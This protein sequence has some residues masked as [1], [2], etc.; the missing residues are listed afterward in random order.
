MPG[1]GLPALSLG[2]TA[3]AWGWESHVVPSSLAIILQDSLT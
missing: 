2:H 3:P 1:Q